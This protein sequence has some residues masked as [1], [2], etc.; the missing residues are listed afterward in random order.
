MIE[1]SL[2]PE[3]RDVAQARFQETGALPPAGATMLGRWHRVAGLA[4][5]VLCETD[6][7]LALGKWMQEWTDV[8]T[9][10]VF[11]VTDDEEFAAVLAG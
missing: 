3:N 1:Y 11:P 2:R 8:L 6:D 9:F 10:D 4:G 5:Y 7:V